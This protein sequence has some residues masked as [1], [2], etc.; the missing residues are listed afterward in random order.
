[1]SKV[2]IYSELGY[3]LSLLRKEQMRI[4]YVV[5]GK[6]IAGGE[7]V[8]LQLMRAARDQGH[9]VCLLVPDAGTVADAAKKENFEVIQLPLERTFQVRKAISFAQ[10]LKT[11]EADLVHT[12]TMLPGMVLARIG[13][14]LAGVP[15][16]CHAHLDHNYNSNPLVK[17][18]QRSADNLTAFLCQTVAVSAD[19]RQALISVGNPAKRIRVIPNGV[20]VSEQVTELAPLSLHTMLNLKADER[21]VGCVARLDPIKGQS[22]LL[23]AAAKILHEIDN[24]HIVFL[25]S[26]IATGGRYETELRAL[27]TQL[28]VTAHTH[29][30]GHQPQA[31]NLMVDL[32]VFVLPSYREAMPMSILEAMAAAKPVVATRVNGVPEVV[33]DGVTGLL[34]P[35]G[36]PD[37][38]AEAILKLLQNPEMARDMGIAGRKRVQK[39]FNLDK[40]HEQVFALYEE[41]VVKKHGVTAQGV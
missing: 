39:H 27:A 22:D 37:A 12:H 2:T 41:V 11:W 35:P 38:L 24:V 33:V 34:V 20:K 32:D 15:I 21:L 28:G 17:L 13:A 9:V 4:V 25:G 6:D 1:V 8:C 10:F 7:T 18:L 14:F 31:A 26:D 29:F 19:T 3:T 40:L 36:N 30:A 5:L 16:I 23:V